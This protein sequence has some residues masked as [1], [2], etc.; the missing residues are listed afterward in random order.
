MTGARP[1]EPLRHRA[2]AGRRAAV[3]AVLAEHGLPR[4]SL[5]H[6]DAGEEGER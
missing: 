6:V 1:S 3:E 4:L 2:R 5:F